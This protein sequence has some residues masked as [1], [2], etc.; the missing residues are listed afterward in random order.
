[1]VA[2]QMPSSIE[3]LNS[4]LLPKLKQSEK[5]LQTEEEQQIMTEMQVELERDTGA[6]NK[7]QT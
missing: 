5:T 2:I 1:M 7:K 6:D 3:Q 4:S